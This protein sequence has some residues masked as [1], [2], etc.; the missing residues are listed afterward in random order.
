MLFDEFLLKLV[1]RLLKLRLLVYFIKLKMILK[2]W[3]SLKANKLEEQQ[4]YSIFKY[5]SKSLSIVL[6]S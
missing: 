5:T 1:G 4:G 2:H 6:H 3:Y